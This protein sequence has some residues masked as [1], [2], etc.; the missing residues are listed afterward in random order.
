MVDIGLIVIEM[1]SYP[2]AVA[3]RGYDDLFAFEFRCY[4]IRRGSI[5]A[6]DANYRRSLAR[7][8]RTYDLIIFPSQSVAKSVGQICHMAFDSLDSGFV[9]ELQALFEAVK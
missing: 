5:R 4:L 3:T 8:A 9:Q 6:P 2:D 1:R 7:R